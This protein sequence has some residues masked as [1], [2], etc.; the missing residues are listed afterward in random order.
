M[1]AVGRAVKSGTE[2]KVIFKQTAPRA[3][4]A[5]AAATGALGRL[6]PRGTSPHRARGKRGAACQ[7]SWI[8]PAAL[9]GQA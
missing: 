1:D 4:E 7:R 9:R 5:A 3:P 6:A 2:K 8:V